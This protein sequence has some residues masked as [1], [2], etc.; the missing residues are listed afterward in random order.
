MYTFRPFKTFEMCTRF[1]NQLIINIFNN[2]HAPTVPKLIKW[3]TF[4]RSA[5]EE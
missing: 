1:I 5:D 2:C 3:K 4:P